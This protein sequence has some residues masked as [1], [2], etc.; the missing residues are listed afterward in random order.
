[1]ALANVFL[2]WFVGTDRLTSWMLQPPTAH[3]AGFTIVAVTALLVFLDFAW[4]REQMCVVA[5]PYAR[6]QSA[7]LDRHSLVV[8]YD[9]KRGEPRA[10]FHKA[11][12][13]TNGDCIDCGACVVTC[14]VG[15]DIRDG[16]QMECVG[17]TQCIDACDSVMVKVGMPRGLIRYTSEA[18]LAGEPR[19]LL[20]P[21]T[22]A[23]PLA[24]LAVTV[25]F[26]VAVVDRGSAEVTVLRGLDTPFAVAPDGSVSN[27]LRVRILNHEDEATVFRVDLAGPAGLQMVA[28]QNPVR[29]EG[30]ATATLPLFAVLPPGAQVH[31]D[32]TATLR[33]TSKHFTFATPVR[34]LG[35]GTPGGSR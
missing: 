20:R 28:P 17:C 8:A 25:A 13:R 3:P 35:P 7:L 15:I 14:P 19:R 34:L 2:A 6:L 4:F 29:I 9:P 18:A 31:G 33:V 10:P 30:G 16:L 24:L 11:E 23:Y 1:V 26:G 32:A 22:V 5:C 27:S 12:E 21:R